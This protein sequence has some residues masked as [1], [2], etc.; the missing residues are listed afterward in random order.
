MSDVSSWSSSKGSHHGVKSRKL[1]GEKLFKK[2]RD[3]LK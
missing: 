2:V 3:V 1:R